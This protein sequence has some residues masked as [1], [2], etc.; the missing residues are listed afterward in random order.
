MKCRK[1]GHIQKRNAQCARPS[2]NK[3][4]SCDKCEER[5]RVK[6]KRNNKINKVINLIRD[7]INK[8]REHIK[9]EVE[10][11]K[12]IAVN[13]RY[14]NQCDRCS[15]HYFTNRSNSVHCDNCIDE[16]EL[17]KTNRISNWKGKYIKC[18]ECG[19]RFEMCSSRSKFCSPKCR[20]KNHYR[21][22]DLKRRKRL[23]ENGKVNY[24]IT[25][26]RLIER[27]GDRCKLCGE[28]VD[29][30]DFYYNEDGHF[31]AGPEYPSIDHIIPV[32][33]GGT[34]TWDNVQLVHKHCNSVKSDSSTLELEDNRVKISI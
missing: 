1:C 7:E 20:D 29:F 31:I 3:E 11:L 27:E 26:K 18:Q 13:H 4:L 9:P 10:A 5:K 22:K 21:T 8:R 24:K 23:Q 15:K 25:K 2:R 6:K 16:I 30:S 19:K 17:E 34:H 32:A 28:P 14:Y 33:K 12:R